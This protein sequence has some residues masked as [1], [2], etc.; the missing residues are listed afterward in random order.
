MAHL[1]VERP[2]MGANKWLHNLVWAWDGVIAAIAYPALDNGVAGPRLIS[3][4]DQSD[5]I[6]ADPATAVPPLA[7]DVFPGCYALLWGL[8]V[9]EDPVATEQFELHIHNAATSYF[10]VGVT[11]AVDMPIQI[12]FP[13]PIKLMTGL[14][15]PSMD[16]SL[17][18]LLHMSVYGFAT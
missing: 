10:E 2:V 8:T 6:F 14:R 17:Q 5:S 11:L 3:D 15:L 12:T 9:V 13:K 18:M 4:V 16:T 7:P 1:P